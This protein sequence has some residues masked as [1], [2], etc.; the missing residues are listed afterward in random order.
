MSATHLLLLGVS[1]L[2]PAA[3]SPASSADAARWRE[4]LHDRQSPQQQSQAALL[5]VA[6]RGD[7][8]A[9]VVRQGLRQTETADVFLALCAALRTARDGRFVDELLTA[10]ASPRADVRLAA[11]E[12]LAVLA[13][14]ELL[15]RLRAVAED[16][17]AD[18][19]RR[20]AA[21]WVL[22]RCGRKQAAAVLLDLLSAK[23]DGLDKSA[24]DALAEL[25]GLAYGTDPA[26]WRAWWERTKDL[27]AERWLEERLAYQAS[28]ARRLEGDLEQARGQLRRVHQQLYARLPPADRLGYVQ[29]LLDQEDPAIRA[30][31]VPWSYEMLTGAD[32]AARR[33]LATVLLRLSQDGV[34]EIQRIAVLALGRVDDERVFERLL[35]LMRTGPVTTRAVA[36]RGLARQARVDGA[37]A[38][39]RQRQVVPA[40]QKA[41][42]D[43][44]VE[45]VL[46]AAEALGSLGVTEAGPV[47][48]ALLRHPSDPMRQTAAQ[49]LE[50]VA[51]ATVL[52]SLLEG[53]DDPAVSVRFS[54]LGAVARAAGEGTTLSDAQ[55]ERLCARLEAV[56]RRDA[57]AGVRGRAATAL[58]DCG[59]P[60]ALPTLW[61]RVLAGEDGR[62][63]EKAWAALVDVVARSASLVLLSQ[64]DRA[65]AE[66][67]QP[68]RRVQLL[69][70][71]H[72]RWRTRDDTRLLADSA[73]ET[74]VQA[75]LDQGKWGAAFPHVRELLGR[76]SSEADLD[77]RLRW[78][79]A[80][81]EQ[82]LGEGNALEALR[83]VQE[84]QG[85]LTRRGLLAA[86]FEKLEK[87]ARRN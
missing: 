6:A 55:R 59:G 65:L 36:A 9:E 21:V 11:A 73:Q 45:V 17:R 31:A 39:E 72:A 51:D 20:Q 81:G 26:P 29:S 71:V 68:N 15:P 85:P 44:A 10:I 23:A 75:Q 28:R 4:M 67:K 86:E 40:L 50:R 48:A 43:P 87:Q 27:P 60:A 32:A 12:A 80:V 84:A 54:L 1:V 62:V 63:Q 34:P 82:A 58:G 78:L 56:L 38:K 8:A 19:S 46:E 13:T 64:W 25:T 47:L 22:G 79:L 33:A 49:A 76:T 83:A 18:L 2:M 69:T 57:D 3:E 77:R 74:L 52:D 14:D 42:A 61:K 66:A 5:L 53:L 35:L 30:L 7:E 41:L 16:A 70:E 24:A 37:E